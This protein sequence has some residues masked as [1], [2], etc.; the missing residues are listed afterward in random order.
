MK[1]PTLYLLCGPSLVGKSS[2]ADAM[3]TELGVD[4]IS[5]DAINVRR[6]YELGDK[7]LTN[8]IW[9]QTLE[10]AL[11]EVITSGMTGQSIVVD[12]TLCF[13]WIRDRYSATA[14]GTGMSVQLLLLNPGI[15]A[16]ETRYEELS[17]S[18]ARPLLSKGDLHRHW[19]EFEWPTEEEL[20]LDV[21]T[22][23]VQEQWL[24]TEKKRFK[25]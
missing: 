20:P 12:D 5:A 6:G 1:I 9:A 24:Q 18:E 8:D 14:K 22:R 7:R 19:N 3:R 13:R 21:T 11:F 16:I 17:L 2:L 15:E 23:E 4:I 25:N 10:I